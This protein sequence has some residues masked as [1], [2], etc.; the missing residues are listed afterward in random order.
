MVSLFDFLMAFIIYIIVLVI[1]QVPVNLLIFIPCLLGAVLIATVTTLGL[2]SFLSALN[3]KFRD[4]KYVIP[5][6]VQVLLFLTPVIYPASI[7]TDGV[8]KVIMALNP[9]TGAI[10]LMRYA[11]GG[12]AVEVSILVV[13]SCCAVVYLVFGMFYFK[14]SESYFADHV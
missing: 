3:I 14:R 11:L 9:L 4:F 13:S 5:Y 8:V 10:G 2:G 7:V 1:Y 12:P 6:S